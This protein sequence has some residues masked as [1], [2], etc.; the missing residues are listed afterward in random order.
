MPT[1]QARWS[2]ALVGSGIV[3]FVAVHAL[4]LTGAGR[5]TLVTLGLY[6][7]VLQ[8]VFGKAFSLVPSYFERDLAWPRAPAITFGLTVPGVAGLAGSTLGAPAVAGT[9]GAVAWAAGVAVFLVSILATVGT[10]LTGAETG[11]GEYDAER[12]PVD[13]VANLFVPVVL[14]YLAVG[15]WATL[16]AHTPVVAPMD[17]Y[18]P[19]ASHLLA[20]GTATLLVFAVGFRLFPRFLVVSVPRW[21]PWVVLVPGALGPALVAVGLPGGPLV[22]AGGALEAVAVVGFALTYWG[23]VGRSDRDRV[24][25]YGPATGVAFG[26]GGVGLGLWFAVAGVAPNLVATHYRL[27]LLGFL[28]LTVV[29]VTYQFYP[30]SVGQFPGATDRTALTTVVALAGGLALDVAGLVAGRPGLTTAGRTLGLA[31]ALGYAS[32][33]VG[34][35]VQRSVR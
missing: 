5:S 25:F 6:G 11:T 26:V 24:G 35:F 30:P 34:V 9:V 23:L 3:S 7:F 15:T 19:R 17:G 18:R 12:R 14:A 8:V 32:L 27:N 2:R 22:H 31:G 21:I 13:R 4:S 28:G 16:S 10:N 1:T 29:G 20:A 33:V